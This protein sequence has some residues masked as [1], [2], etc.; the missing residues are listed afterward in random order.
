MDA[1]P[2]ARNLLDYWGV[3][4]RRRGVIYLCVASVLLATLIG[5]FLVTPLY[6]STVTAQIER[7]NPEILNVRALASTATSVKRSSSSARSRTARSASPST[8]TSSSTRP[9]RR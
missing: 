6:R 1:A 9:T 3:L 7:Q 8:S 5:S 2:R 4:K